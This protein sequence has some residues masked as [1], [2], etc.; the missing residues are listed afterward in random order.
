[1]TIG[2]ISLRL[3]FGNSTKTLTSLARESAK[4]RDQWSSMPSDL[5][6][7]NRE[8]L[9]LART[10]V[11]VGHLRGRERQAFRD[12]HNYVRQ[13]RTR[14]QADYSKYTSSHIRAYEA[15]T[16]AQKRE[17]KFADIHKTSTQIG[18][19]D[20]QQDLI[21]GLPKSASMAFFGRN[22]RG[23]AR[24]F[25]EWAGDTAKG[26]IRG[27]RRRAG[28][29]FGLM[30]AFSAVQVGRKS[31][32]AYEDRVKSIHD[33]G[34]KMGTS[35]H[36]TGD[37]FSYAANRIDRMR[38][39]LAFTLGELKPGMNLMAKLSGT[40]EGAEAAA[41][42]A[43]YRGVNVGAAMR[44]MARMGQFGPI[45]QAPIGHLG[46]IQARLGLAHEVEPAFV[47]TMKGIGY[48]NRPQMFME[49]LESTQRLLGRGQL[50][51]SDGQA[52]QWMSLVS[53]AFGESY[54]NERGKQFI[55]RLVGG[56]SSPMQGVG[57][58]AK[59]HAVRNL[60]VMNLGTEKNPL[61][62]DPRT[63]R[64]AQMIIESGRPEVMS[65]LFEEAVRLG[66][67]GEYGAEIFQSL[68]GLRGR[69]G[70]MQ[71]SALFS[72]LL[73]SGGKMPKIRT[74]EGTT[75]WERL[76]VRSSKGFEFFKL[77][78][79]AEEKVF[80]SV[81]KHLVPVAHD[82]K[83]AAIKLTSGLLAA[84][85]TFAMTGSNMSDVAEALARGGL[86]DARD[87]L[88]GDAARSPATSVIAAGAFLSQVDSWAGLIGAAAG[89]VG[90]NWV[91][92][93]NKPSSK[94]ET[95]VAAPPGSV[96]N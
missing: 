88:T 72:H 96:S 49:T 50:S 80:E 3:N 66:G 84:S 25:G 92:D 60:G 40:V 39:S 18:A 71:S 62:A 21:D 81:G 93:I 36:A 87:I 13:A 64:G 2:N 73:E 5:R 82:F 11:R 14:L 28:Q 59:M 95:P 51:V 63:F 33:L 70:T 42:F 91:A 90:M 10:H 41:G 22:R 6:T 30:A 43:R 48:G 38:R 8:M 85:E 54:R 83:D 35:I 79:D 1:M 9:N 31:I 27:T 89:Y 94:W 29:L 45:A 52:E 24:N 20:A 77:A 26:A 16:D 4:V 53:G 78:A 19:I 37:A 12:H 65:A 44:S 67:R 23:E 56:A 86:T 76:A 32:N 34:V 7:A 57:R 74:G 61:M 17:D 58:H 68:A 46:R 55:H 47:Q 69:G 75:D 15:A